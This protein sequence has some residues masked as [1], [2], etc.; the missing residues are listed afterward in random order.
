[1]TRRQNKPGYKNVGDA[2]AH[3]AQGLFP[4]NGPSSLIRNELAQRIVS[5][6]REELIDDVLSE[7]VDAGILAAEDL[8]TCPISYAEMES[9]AKT[10]LLTAANIWGISRDSINS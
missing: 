5:D 3:V 10:I 2:P 8:G 1:M 7:C 9:L 4:N 6:E